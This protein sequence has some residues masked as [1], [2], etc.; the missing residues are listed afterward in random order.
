[1]GVVKVHRGATRKEHKGT[2]GIDE[3]QLDDAMFSWMLTFVNFSQAV[4][5]IFVTSMISINLPLP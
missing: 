4:H 2:L 1:M 5:F 3:H